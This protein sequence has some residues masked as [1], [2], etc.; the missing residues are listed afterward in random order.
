MLSSEF[1]L[2]TVCTTAFSLLSHL[3]LKDSLCAGRERKPHPHGDVEATGQMGLGCHV[4]AV[5]GTMPLNEE[6]V[7]GLSGL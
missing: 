6:D 1:G 5:S 4:T 3:V 7:A 2:H